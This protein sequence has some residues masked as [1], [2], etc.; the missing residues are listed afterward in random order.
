[1]TTP[2][3]PERRGGTVA[4]DVPQG[5]AITQELCRREFLVDYRPGAGIRVSPHF[6]TKAE[7]CDATLAEIQTILETRAYE[8]HA[9]A[10]TGSF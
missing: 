9:A 8:R 5:L 6:Y 3:D 10:R 4:I 2:K 7:E 1:V